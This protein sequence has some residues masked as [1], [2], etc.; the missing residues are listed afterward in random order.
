M[1]VAPIADPRCGGGRVRCPLAAR[2]HGLM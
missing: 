2:A 1:L